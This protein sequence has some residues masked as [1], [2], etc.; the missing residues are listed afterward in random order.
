MVREHKDDKPHTLIVHQIDEDEGEIDWELR[1]HDSCTKVD[2]IVDPFGVPIQ[3]YDCLVQ[4]IFD[5]CGVREVVEDHLEVQLVPGKFQ[6]VGCST[7]DDYHHESD[8]WIEA[9]E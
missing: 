2:T 6:V 5:N 9:R 1:H 4:Y 8:M 3:E 7:Y